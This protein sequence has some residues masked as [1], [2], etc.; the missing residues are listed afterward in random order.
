[1]KLVGA[2]ARGRTIR[3][4]DLLYAETPLKLCRII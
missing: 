1:M 4:Y 2:R 3:Q